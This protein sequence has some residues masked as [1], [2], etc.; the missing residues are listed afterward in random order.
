MS[1]D[2]RYK[3]IMKHICDGCCNC[4]CNQSKKMKLQCIRTLKAREPLTDEQNRDF[5]VRMQEQGILVRFV[6]EK[7]DIKEVNNEKS[8]S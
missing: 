2:K 5:V 4:D 7:I 8:E 1:D 3:H 6:R